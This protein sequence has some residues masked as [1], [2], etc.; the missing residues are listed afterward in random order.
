MMESMQESFDALMMCFK[1]SEM[2]RADIEMEMV[3]GAESEL[4]SKWIQID[5]KLDSV[6][7]EY[8]KLI[9]SEID[10]NKS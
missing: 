5:D 3:M 6:I 9:Q 4:Q 1:R 8:R 10:K 2:Y 7:E